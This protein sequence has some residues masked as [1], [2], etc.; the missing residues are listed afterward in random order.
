MHHPLIEL[1]RSLLAIATDDCRLE[2]VR[3]TLKTGLVPI[4]TDDADLL[5]NYLLAHGLAGRARWA[6][7]WAYTRFFSHKDENNELTEPQRATLA[8]VNEIRG[9]WLAAVGPW[10]ETATAGPE[11]TAVV[12][13]SSAGLNSLESSPSPPDVPTRY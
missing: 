10:L 6:E 2:S 11:M 4:G 1:V 13:D 12:G 3:L 9:A 7:P 5:E 8:R